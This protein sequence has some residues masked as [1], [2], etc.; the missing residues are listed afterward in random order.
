[1]PS[2]VAGVPDWV[3]E[4]IDELVDRGVY[5]SRS[6]AAR[7]LLEYAVYNKYDESP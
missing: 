7:E 5:N 6:E 1:M 2:V 4:K 3:D